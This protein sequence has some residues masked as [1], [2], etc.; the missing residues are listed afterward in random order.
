[1][2]GQD[3]QFAGALYRDPFELHIQGI[4]VRTTFSHRHP[5]DAHEGPVGVELA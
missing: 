4:G 5:F 1:V 3:D 2:I